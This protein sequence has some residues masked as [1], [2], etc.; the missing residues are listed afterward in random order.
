MALPGEGSWDPVES[1]GRLGG[2]HCACAGERAQLC[3]VQAGRERGGSERGLGGI[4][5]LGE[6]GKRYPWVGEGG[7][8]LS[9]MTGGDREGRE[10]GR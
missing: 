3:A 6:E 10:R 7:E 4:G 5:G 8:G 9:R 1:P 2:L